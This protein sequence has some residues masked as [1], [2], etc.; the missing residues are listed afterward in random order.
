ML[1]IPAPY[2]HPGCTAFL[3][4]TAE[5]VRLI[6]RNADGTCLISIADRRFPS[7]RASGNRTVPARD[8]HE[9]P[10]GALGRPKRRAARRKGKG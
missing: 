10:T 5:E 2:P 4:G 8:L 6:Q 1:N 9:T 3:A 7:E